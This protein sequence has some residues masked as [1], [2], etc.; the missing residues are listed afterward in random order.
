[1][2]WLLIAVAVVLAIALAAAV[3]IGIFVATFDINK[4]KGAIVKQI[5][6]GIG[7]PVEIGGLSLSWN[8]GIVLGVEGF[9]IYT[10]EDGRRELA[11]SV[12]RASASVKVA[13]LLARQIG[14]SSV[15]LD[16]PRML[17]VKCADGRIEVKGLCP[18][19]CAVTGT[20]MPKAPAGV[21][22]APAAKAKGAAT[23]PVGF[24]ID[25]V[26]IKGGEA[27][28]VDLSNPDTPELDIRS[29]DA[30]IKDI[31]MTAP[32]RFSVKMALAGEGQNVSFAG[33]AG[34]FA[35]GDIFLKAF[36]M[37]A[38]LS[39]FSG[40]EVQKA[41]PALRKA[42]LR[43]GMSGMV[44]VQIGELRVS[45]GKV[46]K[47]SGNLSITGG[48]LV[49]A[50]LRVP[51]ENI[52]LNTDFEGPAVVVRQF[53]AQI[54][55]G[56]LKGSARI[57]DAFTSPRTAVDGAIE[58]NGLNQFVST[59]SPLRQNLDGNARISFAGS[60]SGNSWPDI[61]RTLAGRGTMSLDNGIIMDANVL[62]QSIGALTLF[63]DLLGSVQGKVPA[64]EKQSFGTKYTVLKPLNQ[65][66]TI[67]GGYIMLPDLT[68]QSTNV[69]MQGAAKMSLT[70]DLSGSGMIRF[71]PAI[72]NAMI[73][74][75]P[76]MRAVA[77]PQGLITFP[78][79]FKGGGGAFRVIPDMKYIGQRVAVQAAGD[80]ISGYLS[81]SAGDGSQAK[82]QPEGAAQKPPKIKDF[83][84]ALAAESK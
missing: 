24:R 17:I 62:D 51:V 8:G 84:K 39:A 77:D 79:A 52:T 65:Q 75:V 60:M 43:D 16:R 71:S 56:V 74:A 55:N 42:G 19:T 26:E 31:S 3:A 38:D 13:P 11:L 1:M 76:Q 4:Y 72:S 37:D 80:V 29:L 45:G 6:A 18:R 81:K 12:D 22:A 32:A 33:T 23:Q 36:R 27:K 63:P 2:K 47:L 69:D 83:L 44:R 50:Q 28:F 46:A 68:L 61:S 34:G 59:V 67:E 53:S 15:R 48:R 35:T 73:S 64:Q 70:G 9:K 25:S 58:V 49:F 40:G 21:S 10:T 66:F 54:A 57:D 30:E 82:A 78:I 5:E 41:L 7:N 14:I 20:D